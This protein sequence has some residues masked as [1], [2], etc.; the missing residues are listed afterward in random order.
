MLA[1]CFEIAAAEVAYSY[2]AQEEETLVDDV[3]HS[4]TL[5]AVGTVDGSETS[6]WT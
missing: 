5:K 3:V 4:T 6:D 1:C 2:T